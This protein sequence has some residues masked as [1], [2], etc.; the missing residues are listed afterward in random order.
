MIKRVHGLETEYAMI[1]LCNIMPYY[2]Q[3]NII[4]ILVN[5]FDQN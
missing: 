5:S 4:K 2:D 1:I 3:E